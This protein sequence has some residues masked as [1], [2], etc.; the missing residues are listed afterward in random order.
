MVTTEFL[1]DKLEKIY[2]GIVEAAQY[3]DGNEIN[4]YIDFVDNCPKSCPKDINT[5]RTYEEL[6][7][8]CL[9]KGVES[10]L[11]RKDVLNVSKKHFEGDRDYPSYDY[12]VI[13]TIYG[14]FEYGK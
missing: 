4:S 3:F 7:N 1:L 8:K 6:K 9:K 13:E 11:F 5:W 12:L 10:I 14:S 2:P